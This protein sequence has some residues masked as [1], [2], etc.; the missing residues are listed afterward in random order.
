MTDAI[1]RE[2]LEQYIKE[3]FKVRSKPLGECGMKVDWEK[4]TNHKI[5]F[6][7]DT[8]GTMLLSSSEMKRARDLGAIRKP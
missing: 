1:T 3:V 2:F 4:M 6:G 8:D 5:R 7:F